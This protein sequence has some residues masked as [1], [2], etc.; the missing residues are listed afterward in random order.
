MAGR[1]WKERV[2]VVAFL[3]VAERTNYT[4]FLPYLESFPNFLS[5]PIAF[6]SFFTCLVLIRIWCGNSELRGENPT[7]AAATFSC[8]SRRCGIYLVR[9]GIT[10]PDPTY[11]LYI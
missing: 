3:L 5:V 4:K 8:Y 11:M 7:L 1:G 6:V 9:V 10:P 2:A